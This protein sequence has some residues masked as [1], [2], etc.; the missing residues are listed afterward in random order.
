MAEESTPEEDME[1]IDPTLD[2]PTDPNTNNEDNELPLISTEDNIN[3]EEQS[4]DVDMGVIS[5]Q[6]S[7]QSPDVAIDALEDIQH[8][9]DNIPLDQFLVEDPTNTTQPTDTTAHDRTLSTDAGAGFLSFFNMGGDDG[10]GDDDA[11]DE[12]E[13][14]SKRGQSMGGIDTLDYDTLQIL[15][16]EN[17]Q[18]FNENT[19]SRD[20]GDENDI[21]EEKQAQPQSS[22]IDAD[23]G[24]SNKSARGSSG[25]QQDDL[26]PEQH[27]QDL[28]NQPDDEQPARP[29][30]DTTNPV[31]DE[32]DNIQGRLTCAF[33]VI[34][35]IYIEYVYVA[36][37]RND[38]KYV[39][40]IQI[41][42][43]H[44]NMVILDKDISQRILLRINQPEEVDQELLWFMV[45]IQR[46][47]E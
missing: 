13:P 32:M 21:D 11:P 29:L 12:I 31:Q 18:K 4:G 34:H 42:V 46:I 22:R 38:I 1:I 3:D 44:W 39:Y 30:I 40:I 14:A 25:S 5:L 15:N 6:S 19:L 33:Y 20:S 23:D 35:S 2:H 26:N 7:I 45:M 43:C 10:G 17:L 47:I 27:N 8:E 37:L 16:D 9:Q 28:A 36:N 24:H 41:V